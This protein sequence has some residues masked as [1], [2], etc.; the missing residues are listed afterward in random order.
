MQ[1]LTLWLF[2]LFFPL[3]IACGAPDEDLFTG[4]ADAG[5]LGVAEQAIN[6][7]SSGTYTY[8]WEQV[9][10]T[11]A[12]HS[13]GPSSA[14]MP[15]SL[16][17]RYKILT[18][19]A[20]PACATP[21]GQVHQHSW[22]YQVRRSMGEIIPHAASE[23]YTV[24]FTV[25]EVF[26][27]S[28]NVEFRAGSCPGHEGDSLM[29][30]FVCPAMAPGAVTLA[31]SLAGTYKRYDGKLTVFID[32]E[33]IWQRVRPGAPLGTGCDSG[34]LVN[35]H[36]LAEHV[37]HLAALYP[38]GQ[39]MYPEDKYI[40]VPLCPSWSSWL[41]QPNG[42]CGGGS[43]GTGGYP[44]GQLCRIASYNPTSL[45]NNYLLSPGFCPD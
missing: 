19:T 42:P 37:G 13:P 2:G 9:G 21:A 43:Y 27:N 18:N 33:D 12:K 23:G 15:G 35:L 40:P 22:I 39:G 4:P 5:D 6:S 45:P 7:R 10:Y 44:P 32:Q 26:D 1:R 41:V 31:E 30:S 25:T 34:Y 8:G 20:Y 3:A 16:S 14:I 17:I 11:I 36:Q 24:P 28:A 29:S 38:F